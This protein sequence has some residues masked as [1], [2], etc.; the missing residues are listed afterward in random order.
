VLSPRCHYIKSLRLYLHSIVN[1]ILLVI[2]HEQE[3]AAL[4][5]NNIRRGHVIS[6]SFVCKSKG[7]RYGK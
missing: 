5:D 6:S 7:D 4:S 3:C 2:D 1:S